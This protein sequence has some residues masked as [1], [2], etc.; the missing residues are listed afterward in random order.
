[1]SSV[2]GIVEQNNYNFFGF[3]PKSDTH[4]TLEKIDVGQMS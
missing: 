3:E 4:S 1:M 2:M